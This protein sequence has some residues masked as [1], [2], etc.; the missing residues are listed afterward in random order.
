VDDLKR[1]TPPRRTRRLA[2]GVTAL[3]AVAQYLLWASAFNYS[4]DV[5]VIKS[6]T[7]SGSR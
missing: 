5:R 6:T 1:L 7:H 3:G 2:L 4:L